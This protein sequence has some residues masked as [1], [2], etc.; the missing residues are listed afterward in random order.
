MAPTSNSHARSYIEA[1]G[2]LN[3][4][5]FVPIHVHHYVSVQTYSIQNFQNPPNRTQPVLATW[6]LRPLD[7]HVFWTVPED[8]VPTNVHTSN[9]LR[10]RTVQCGSQLSQWS[11]SD[12]S[13]RTHA[14]EFFTVCTKLAEMAILYSKD[15]TTAKKRVTSSGAWPDA[16]DYYWFRSPVPNQMS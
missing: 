14:V 8:T 1:L 12:H 5:N 2:K 9:Y 13:L 6:P 10:H 16:T 15:I 7:L 3:L 11:R 4:L